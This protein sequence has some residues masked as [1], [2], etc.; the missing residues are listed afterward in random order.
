ML[1]KTTLNL[2]L[3]KCHPPIKARMK[4]ANTT[5]IH[6]V[7]TD[8]YLYTGNILMV[9]IIVIKLLHFGITTGM[10]NLNRGRQSALL[11]EQI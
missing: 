1:L 9:L 5:Y 8:Y 2:A 11:Q 10:Q 3:S 6:I 7:Y 4:S